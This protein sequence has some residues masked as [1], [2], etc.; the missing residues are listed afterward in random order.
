M[1]IESFQATA[2]V[3][4]VKTEKQ[5]EKILKK[6]RVVIVDT[7]D[8]LEDQ[9]R[10]MAEERLTVSKEDLKG[11]K[12]FFFK[13]WK[14]NLFREY[15]RQK[16]I[17]LAKTK[18]IESGN[19][20]V[21]ENTDQTVHYEA[22]NAIVDRFVKE[23]EE[24]IHTEAGEERKIVGNE[25]ADDQHLN[26]SVRAL[27]R[28]FASGRIDE[29]AFREERNRIIANT[30]GFRGEKLKNTVSHTDNLLEVARQS[31]MAIEHGASLDDI[32]KEI[33]VVIGKAKVGVRSESKYNIV[34]R[35]VAKIQSSKIG[36]YLNEATI[37]SGVA[38]AYG[39]TIGLS[40]RFARS[41]ALAWGTFGAS[42]FVGGAVAGA[43]ESVKIEDERRQHS[44]E[45]AKGKEMA[46]E[47]TRRME[48]EKLIYKMTSAKSL[49]ES[50]KNTAK[51]ILGPEDFFGA[52]KVLAEAEARIKLSDSEQVDLI[53]YANF[54]SIERERLNLD[55]TRAEAKVK[56]RKMVADGT[57]DLPG[58]K[59]F[60]EFYSS[61]MET[62]TTVLHEGEGG[63]GNER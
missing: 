37:A 17:A 43:R 61:A 25:N 58:G 26:I 28:E 33:E 10:D 27:V 1:S 52:V 62:Q 34:D 38:I 5:K 41:K 63:D 18:I 16:E 56:L 14:H 21:G 29:N 59:S 11:M 6:K 60:D 35:I 23:Y 7:S 55:I 40:Q 57:I 54:K 51:R 42:A 53:S 48:M 15:Y 45:R 9:A 22:M 19:L 47:M 32:D 4:S 46:G 36:Q 49:I 24:T 44:R 39:A 13:I 31:K 30:T 12:G 2:P 8:A 50:I 3:E 20:Y